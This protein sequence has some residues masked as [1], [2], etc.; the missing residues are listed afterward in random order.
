MVCA[1]RLSPALAG[2]RPPLSCAWLSQPRG[3]RRQAAAHRLADCVR[4]ILRCNQ[5]PFLR[6]STMSR[7]RSSFPLPHSKAA[8][9]SC[10]DRAVVARQI[11]L[12]L[13]PSGPAHR[14]WRQSAERGVWAFIHAMRGECSCLGGI[15]CPQRFFVSPG[16]LGHFAFGSFVHP[17]PSFLRRI[18]PRN[19]RPDATLYSIA[20]VRMFPPRT[21][22]ANNRSM[23]RRVVELSNEN[24]E[25]PCLILLRTEW[26]RI[27]GRATVADHLRRNPYISEPIGERSGT[28]N[29]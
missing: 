17:W 25:F 14:S 23:I 2:C 21:A 19:E 29:S 15:R 12:T 20:A 9:C 28:S 18:P 7:R 6:F 11:N 13:V 22:S 4:S 3:A 24:P 16:R 10:N 26:M 5:S 27:I 8:H 1:A